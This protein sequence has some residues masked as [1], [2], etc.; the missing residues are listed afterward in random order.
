MHEVKPYPDVYLPPTQL[1]QLGAPVDEDAVPGAHCVQTLYAELDHDPPL[2]FV[3]CEA[4]EPDEYF[5]EGHAV[6]ESAFTVPT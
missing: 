5:P 3:H 6:G 2:Q 1:L 4:P